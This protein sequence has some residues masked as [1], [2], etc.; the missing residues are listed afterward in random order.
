MLLLS[1]DRP[2]QSLELTAD[3]GESSARFYER[4][5]DVNNA[6]FRQRWLSFVS[7]GPVS[8]QQHM[9]TKPLTG[10]RGWLLLFCLTMTVRP[11]LALYTLAVQ[12]PA[13]RTQADPKTLLLVYYCLSISIACFGLYSAFL[14]W[15]LSHRAIRVTKVYLCTLLVYWISLTLFSFFLLRHAPTL[16]L[17]TFFRILQKQLPAAIGYSL[18]WLFYLFR[19]KRVANTYAPEA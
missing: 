17:T 1:S 4:V 9:S 16:P 14:L 3:R 11:L 6:R 13:F 2:N 5:L 19:S 12:L 10:I 8:A 18:L 15:T 7:L